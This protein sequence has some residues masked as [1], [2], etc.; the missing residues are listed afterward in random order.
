M[1]GFSR[2]STG[3]NWRKVTLASA[4]VVALNGVTTSVQS[5]TFTVPPLT[6]EIK[7]RVQRPTTL[8]PL[9]WDSSGVVEVSLVMVIDGQEHRCAGRVSGGIKLNKLGEE[10]P[11]YVLT[12][13][14]TKILQGGV[15]RRLGEL[16]TTTP[17]TAYVRLER[18]SGIANTTLISAEVIEAPRPEWI[19]HNSVAF[20]A[21]TDGNETGG[22][23]VMSITHTAA[24][25]D[26]AAFASNGNGAGTPQAST[27]IT[28]AGNAM[29]EMWDLG[30]FATYFRTAGYRLAGAANVPT[31][32]QTITSTLAGAADEHAMGVITMT[33]VDSTTPVGTAATATGVFPDVSATVTVGSVGADDLVI[34]GL[35]IGDAGSTSPTAT[36]GAD[37][38]GR[39]AEPILT[40][41]WLGQSSQPGTAGGVMSW[42]CSAGTDGWAIG[43]VAF[44]PAAAGGRT[45]KNTRSWPLGMEIGMGWRMEL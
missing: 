6:A 16:A 18:I 38:T 17:S 36:A 26:R 20:D 37:Q 13:K 12:Y 4:V 44:K 35:F 1:I 19:P 22:D 23:G 7:L 28:Y 41:E 9:V 25:S 40:F 31:G 42:A 27:S 24:G 32:A 11:E 10:I 45:T 43:A 2:I 5:S 3:R 30:P 34:D 8:A 29:T 14:P 21:A 15:C 33:G 39:N